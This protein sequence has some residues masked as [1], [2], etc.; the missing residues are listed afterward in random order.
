MKFFI[1]RY[2]RIGLPA[3]DLFSVALSGFVNQPDVP[4]C[5]FKPCSGP[6]ANSAHPATPNTVATNALQ[7]EPWFHGSVSRKEAEEL[8]KRDGDFLVRESST[9]KGQFVLSGLQDGQYK[10]LLLVDPHGVV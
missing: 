9:T 2:A 1:S 3:F 7:G 4:C 6:F 8:L 10:H 5:V